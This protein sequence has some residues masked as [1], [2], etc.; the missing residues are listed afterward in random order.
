MKRIF[1]VFILSLTS[2][3]AQN[4]KETRIYFSENLTQPNPQCVEIFTKIAKTS[5]YEF[6][7]YR[8]DKNIQWLKEYIS[9]EFDTWN[10][11]KILV[12]LFFDWGDKNNKEFQGTG[13]ITWFEYDIKTQTLKDNMQEK[14]LV[15]NQNLANKFNDCLKYCNFAQTSALQNQYKYLNVDFLMRNEIIGANSKERAYFYSA[16]DEKCKIN[17]L[18]LIPKDKINLLQNKGEF[19]FV[20]YKRQNGEFIKL[21]IKSD[22]VR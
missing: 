15:I 13:T 22:R 7:T 18:F 4:P 17:D 9:F 5:N 11:D 12:K 19:S 14:E 8:G 20:A 6:E 2:T 3:F 10:N 21:W 16:P 1:M